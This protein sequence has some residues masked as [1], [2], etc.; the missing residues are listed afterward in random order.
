MKADPIF[1]FS[2]GRLP[3]AKL[4]LNLATS[5][6]LSRIGA[7]HPGH[8]LPGANTHGNQRPNWIG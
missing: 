5:V 1:G 3:Q 6:N 4:G 7:R 2:D 8:N